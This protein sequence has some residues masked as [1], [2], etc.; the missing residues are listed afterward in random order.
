MDTCNL[1]KPLLV[2]QGN[3]IIGETGVLVGNVNNMQNM[4]ESLTKI[5]SAA[6]KSTLDSHAKAWEP[7]SGRQTRCTAARGP[8]GTG[9]RRWLPAS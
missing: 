2:F 5:Q 6:G 9:G 7:A 3:L 4:L 8:A 1:P